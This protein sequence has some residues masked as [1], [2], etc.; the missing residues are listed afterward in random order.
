MKR[1]V[2]VGTTGSG[3]T[4]LA[5]ELAAKLGLAHID[6]DDLHHLPGWK[7]RPR[8]GF[9]RLLIEATQAEK[10]AIAGNYKA[11]SQ[12]ITFPMADTIIWLDMPFWNNFWR[13]LE[14]TV[15]RAYTGEMICNG[16]TEPF[17]RQFYSKHSILWW[18]LKTWHK[19]RKIYAAMFDNPQDHQHLALVRLCSYRQT[20]DFLDKAG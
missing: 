18:F 13:L 9:R 2:I 14:R 20:R 8:E 5:R 3:K 7:E 17:W 4:T 10:W 6:L 1:I 12:D 15:R 19:N 16:N 11:Q